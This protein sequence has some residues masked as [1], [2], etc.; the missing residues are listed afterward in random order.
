MAGPANADRA[1]EP[2]LDGKEKLMGLWNWITGGLR[3]PSAQE[4]AEHTVDRMEAEVSNMVLHK[5]QKTARHEAIGYIRARVGLLIRERLT[6][7][8][9]SMGFRAPK[10]VEEA[11][12]FAVA[13]LA[14]RL[15]KRASLVPVR[16]E[17]RRVA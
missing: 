17:Y 1:N 14:R 11:F 6:A 16:T 3:V 4:L 7:N 9:A 15:T 13:I 5:I 10:V 2:H 8:L 12:D